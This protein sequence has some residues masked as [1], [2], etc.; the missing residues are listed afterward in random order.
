MTDSGD[1]PGEGTGHRGDQ[2]AAP[3]GD[4]RPS[5]PAGARRKTAP[6]LAQQRLMSQIATGRRARQQRAMVAI[7]GAMS[8]LVL[9]ASGG[10]WLLTSYV[11]SH[12]GRVNAGTTGTPTSGPLNILL[13][14]VDIRAGLTAHQ[15]ARLHVGHDISD[16][17]DTLMLVHIPASHR[18]IQVVSLPRDSWVSVP[19][20]GMNKINSAYGTGGARLMVQTVEA[21]TGLSINDYAEVNFLGFVKIINAVGGVNVCLPFAVDDDYSGLHLSA[22]VHHVDGLT[23]LEFARDRHSFATSDLARIDNQQQMMSTILTKA[24]SAGTLSDPFKLRQVLSSVTAAVRVDQHFNVLGLADELR[25]IRPSDVSF[26]TVPLGNLNYETPDG[27][28]AVLWDQAAAQRLFAQIRADQP[29]ANLAA[30]AGSRHRRGRHHASATPGTG[31]GGGSALDSPA[32][33][34]RTAAQDAC[35]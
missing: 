14:G 33:T 29:P 7:L 30:V 26:S 23:A 2:P 22:G 13:A 6:L 11:T 9:F 24:A 18:Y 35:H 3:G 15:Q 8:A 25:G 16:N 17:S 32:G 34:A 21:A 19:G 28:S 1:S 4:T 5:R 27:Q 10:A 31:G 12:L 20:H